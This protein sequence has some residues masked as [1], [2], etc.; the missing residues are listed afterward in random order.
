VKLLEASEYRV[1]GSSEKFH[2]ICIYNTTSTLHYPFAFH[3]ISSSCSLHSL[4]STLSLL[5]P[6]Y[7]LAY[8]YYSHSP[9]EERAGVLPSKFEARQFQATFQPPNSKFSTTSLLLLQLAHRV[10]GITP[11]GLLSTGSEYVCLAVLCCRGRY[12]SVQQ[13]TPLLHDLSRNLAPST[14]TLAHQPVTPRTTVP[15]RSQSW[16]LVAGRI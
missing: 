10:A 12:I 16:L 7:P 13:Q 15:T 8:I 9:D 6:G 14:L 3:M 4:P 11:P 5:N 2:Y 1:T